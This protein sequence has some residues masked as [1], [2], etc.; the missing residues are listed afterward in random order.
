ML[1][2][3]GNL[4]LLPYGV[5]GF[6][7]VG[8]ALLPAIR[9]RSTLAVTSVDIRATGRPRSNPAVRRGRDERRP[10]AGGAL[11]ARRRRRAR[12][13]DIEFATDA[14]FRRSRRVRVRRTDSLGGALARVTKLEPGGA[15]T[16]G[17]G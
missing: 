1:P 6:E 8:R 10:D 7:P 5:Q 14:R 9:E 3:L 17:R 16:G 2:A 13:V 11:R 4:H 12:R 15:C